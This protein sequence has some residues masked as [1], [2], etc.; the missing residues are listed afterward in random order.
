MWS[1]F[2]GAISESRWALE[3][4][5]HAFLF[6]LLHV[7][8]MV[9]LNKDLWKNP[10]LPSPHAEGLVAQ[11]VPALAHVVQA[12]PEQSAV[13]RV[14]KRGHNPLP[15]LIQSV[16]QLCVA[17]NL[18]LKVLWYEAHTVRVRL[19]QRRH[20]LGNSSHLSGSHFFH[21]WSAQ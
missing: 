17:V 2:H 3:T 10:S 4:Q 14:P 12:S 19:T 1:L 21:C 6:L 11:V 9:F 18:C 7:N 20:T 13:L 8:S 16:I 15:I 5:I